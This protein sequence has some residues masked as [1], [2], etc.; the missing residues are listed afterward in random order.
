MFFGRLATILALSLLTAS[1]SAQAQGSKPVWTAAPAPEAVLAAYPVD[2]LTAGIGG[3]AVL[4]CHVTSQGK[5]RDCQGVS[6]TPPDQ[7][8]KSAAL[9]LVPAFQMAPKLAD[10]SAAVSQSFNIPIRFSPPALP[11]EGP[12]RAPVF[13]KMAAYS[14]L[15]GP[16]PFYPERAFR[17]GK[18]GLVIMQCRAVATGRLMGCEVLSASP[19]DFDFE[20][21]AV[22]MTQKKDWLTVAPRLVEG[23]PVDDEIVRV[24][25]PF[26]LKRR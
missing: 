3:L 14:D 16:G 6:E 25:V 10:G 18:D 12:F 19:K 26:V 20:S 7:G 2:A 21:A 17:A 11:G 9:A 23:Q 5:L 15:G 13:K 4:L 24:V 8:F 22:V 1:G